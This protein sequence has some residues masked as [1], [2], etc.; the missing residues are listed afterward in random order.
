MALRFLTKN[1]PTTYLEGM[2]IIVDKPLTWSSFHVVNKIRNTISKKIGRNIKVGHA[3]TL[4]PMATG[5]L[6]LATGKFTPL[7][8]NLQAEDKTYTGTFFMGATTP[9]YDTETQPDALFDT[10]H[11]NLDYLNQVKKQFIGEIQQKPPIFSA[12]KIDGERLY[13][14]A[15][16][17]QEVD[18]QARTVRIDTFDIQKFE[19]PD[20][21]FEVKCS[22][23]TYIRSLA[24]DFGKA[25]NSGAYL[26][27]LCRTKSG[28]FTIEQAWQM[29]DLVE[30]ILKG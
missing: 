10:K 17:G 26:K 2:I 3:G 1:E 11:L 25:C 20:I 29:T 7:L 15:R 30:F 27:S 16:L 21:D 4:D 6:V 22:K 23:G 5:V 13:E 18:I 24:Y 8:Q 28:D 9:S 12:I 14:K 19:L